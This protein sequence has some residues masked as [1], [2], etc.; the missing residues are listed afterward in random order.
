MAEVL[1]QRDYE[2]A[3]FW[4]RFAYWAMMICPTFVPFNWTRPLWSAAGWYAHDE[5]YT[6]YRERWLAKE[7]DAL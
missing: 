5:G 4:G 1:S 3:V 6:S 2:R 7:E